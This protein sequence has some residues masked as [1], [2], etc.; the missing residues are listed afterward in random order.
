MNFNALFGSRKASGGVRFDVADIPEIVA[1]L[2]FLARRPEIASKISGLTPSPPAEAAPTIREFDAV[3][4]IT[5]IAERCDATGQSTRDVYLELER[6]TL[7]P[8]LGADVLV[9]ITLVTLDLDEPVDLGEDVS[10]EPLSEEV[11]RA[12][13]TAIQGSVNAFLVSAATHAVVLKN[14]TFDNARGPLVRRILMD[15]KPPHGEDIEQVFQALQI[16]SGQ[17]VGYVQI[18]LR[19]IGWADGWLGDLPPIESVGS[20]SRLPNELSDRGWNDTPLRVTSA[21]VSN[22]ADTYTALRGTH[23]RGRLAARRL[24]QSALRSTSED[25]LL[26]A[27]IGIEAL[28]GEEHDELVH[29]MGLRA[30]VALASLGW[31][32]ERAYEVLKKVYGHR[33]KIVH[34]T[35][36]SNATI[37]IDGKKYETAST[38]IYLLRSLLQ[39]HLRANPTWTP[40]SLDAALNV[41]IDGQLGDESRT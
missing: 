23:P 17:Q 38:A 11:Q 1:V 29:R 31:S 12:R 15:L 21:D 9:P 8:H 30:S 4:F 37:T 13:A 18:C 26:D 27:C 28:L 33:S 7:A 36:P 35:E 40:K 5:E 6:G 39:S 20:V 19:P 16:V 3:R 24:F 34:G 32:A 25:A 10:I 2:E 14:R 22:L 41:A